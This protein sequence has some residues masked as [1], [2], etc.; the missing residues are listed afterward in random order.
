MTCAQ[1]LYL[2]ALL[3]GKYTLYWILMVL[4]YE[5]LATGKRAQG[6]FKDVYKRD[7]RVLDMGIERCEDVANDLS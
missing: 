3:L 2:Y 5:E 1:L 7:M 4:L 6:Q